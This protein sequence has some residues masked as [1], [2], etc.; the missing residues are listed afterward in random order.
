MPKEHAE[1]PLQ[2]AVATT[3][4]HIQ[5]GL[6]HYARH[7]QQN[8]VHM[9][10]PFEEL[11]DTF[12][13]L[14]LSSRIE[15]TNF[16]AGTILLDFLVLA[17]LLVDC[18]D[19][20]TKQVFWKATD[21]I[22]KKW[23]YVVGYLLSLDNLESFIKML[24]KS[25]V[26]FDECFL[27]VLKFQKALSRVVTI[28]GDL[29]V[30]FHTLGPIFRIFYGGFLQVFQTALGWKRL[31]LKVSECYQLAYK[32]FNLVFGEVERMLLD[33]FE[34][35]EGQ[36]LMACAAVQSV[37]H[38]A[39]YYAKHFDTWFVEQ[40]TKSEDEHRRYLCNFAY[41][42]WGF[43]MLDDAVR[44][45]CTP[46]IEYQICWWAP[47]WLELGKHRHY[48]LSLS[49]TE[50]LYRDLPY[51]I[52]QEIRI[53]RTARF[54]AGKDRDGQPMHRRE[55]HHVVETVNGWQETAVPVGK[56]MEARQKCSSHLVATRRSMQYI[57]QVFRQTSNPEMNQDVGNK[58]A[59]TKH[60]SANP[61]KAL[62]YE[63][64]VLGGAHTIAPGQKM[65]DRRYWNVLPE[66]TTDL[67]NPKKH[68]NEPEKK[69]DLIVS[70]VKMAL[71][72]KD[73]EES[74]LR[75]NSMDID[76]EEAVGGDSEEDEAA[77][78]EDDSEEGIA[79]VVGMLRMASTLHMSL[80]RMIPISMMGL[81][82]SLMTTSKTAMQT[83]RQWQYPRRQQ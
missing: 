40:R 6:L 29:H 34:V 79:M 78:L 1:C 42:G 83:Q 41:L 62:V 8:A 20:V 16:G 56:T 73:K 28:P 67:K 17:G 63:M 80:R 23:V 50:Q 14:P 54:Y 33:C 36:K 45:G 25:K 66:M 5:Q 31:K 69:E 81:T 61:D 9:W 11:A 72:Q 58:K 68:R 65:T 37:D 59:K 3:L 44:T 30:K 4:H 52:L 51:S 43:M 10:N 2:K 12:A 15:G 76:E 19:P 47:V 21:D 57:D 46:T 70:A 74:E 13:I 38:F 27:Q 49:Q 35:N 75:V 18:L 22:A 24:H 64:L 7:F 55:M 71:S 60:P 48:K 77:Q 82:M 39:I 32:L 53:N 26:T